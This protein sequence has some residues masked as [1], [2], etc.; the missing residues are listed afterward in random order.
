M[1]LDFG[2]CTKGNGRLKPLLPERK[3]SLQTLHPVRAGGLCAFVAAMK[4]KD[5]D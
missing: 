4:I 5:E 3:V 2:V 1:M